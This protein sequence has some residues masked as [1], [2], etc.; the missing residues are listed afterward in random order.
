MSLMSPG[1]VEE[2]VKEIIIIS[3]ESYSKD[4]TG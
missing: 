1:N 2:E 3:S 4:G